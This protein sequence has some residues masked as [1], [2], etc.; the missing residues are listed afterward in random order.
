MSLRDAPGLAGGRLIRVAN[1]ERG[2]FE[3][4]REIVL[5][6][7]WRDAEHIG[8]VVEAEGRI[9]GGQERLSI[10]I[11]REQIA[12]GV[13]VFGPIEAVETGPA[14]IRGPGGGLIELRFEIRRRFVIGRQRRPGRARGRHGSGTQLLDDFFP[15]LRVS[16]GV[17]EIFGVERQATGFKPLVVA[18]GAVHLGDAFVEAFWPLGGAACN[19]PNGIAARLKMA[20]ASRGES[21]DP[22]KQLLARHYIAMLAV[23]VRQSVGRIGVAPMRFGR[24]RSLMAAATA[25]SLHAFAQG[26]DYAKIEILTEKVAPNLI[27]VVGIGGRRSGS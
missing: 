25:V 20:L 27:C 23:Q 15:E 12:D 8:H 3:G 19:S 6:E 18:S 2:D 7:R 13:G 26:I 1:R 4:G 16:G 24:Q 17:R 22:V 9:V 21:M 14:G 10:D 11:E 5:L